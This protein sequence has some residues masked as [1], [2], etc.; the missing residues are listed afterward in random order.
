MYFDLC[1]YKYI[2]TAAS[3][4]GYD[5][6]LFSKQKSVFSI[7]SMLMRIR[8]LVLHYFDNKFRKMQSQTAEKPIRKTP[9]QPKYFVRKYCHLTQVLSGGSAFCLIYLSCIFLHNI[10][11]F[12]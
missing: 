10:D 5:G 8:D 7:Y 12:Y 1:I 4:F 6:S 11:K 9:I 2:C 3:K